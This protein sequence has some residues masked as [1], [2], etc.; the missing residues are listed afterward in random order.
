MEK[1]CLEG[2]VGPFQLGLLHASIILRHSKF[3]QCP[4]T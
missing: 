4:F 2:I 3:I 1:Y